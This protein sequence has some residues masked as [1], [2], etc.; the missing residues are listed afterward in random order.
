MEG[1]RRAAAARVTA[2]VR[3]L[4]GAWPLVAYT[5][6]GGLAGERRS[7]V[8]V[9]GLVCITDCSGRRRVRAVPRERRLALQTELR[10]VDR[11]GLASRLPR[12]DRRLR[13]AY[14]YRLV[15]GGTVL[16]STGFG[17]PPELRRVVAVLESLGR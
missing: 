12:E 4:H 9:S 10:A 2:A 15:V 13:D 11:R 3:A 6:T 8:V 7:I 5:A 1:H 16:R 14:E 17:L